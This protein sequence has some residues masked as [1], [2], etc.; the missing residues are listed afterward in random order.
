VTYAKQL[1]VKILV[2]CIMRE[3]RYELFVD[4]LPVWGLVGL[5]PEETKGALYIYTHKTLEIAYNGNQVG[6]LIPSVIA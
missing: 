6:T 1:D 5:P 4:D 2:G 3:R